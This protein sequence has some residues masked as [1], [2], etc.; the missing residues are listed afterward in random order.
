LWR[1]FC[2]M[3]ALAY[4]VIDTRL[5]LTFIQEAPALSNHIT[6]QFHDCIGNPSLYN[7]KAV[8]FNLS[9]LVPS[10][11]IP[12][13]S[14]IVTRGAGLC[15]SGMLEPIKAVAAFASSV[16]I[17]EAMAA[18]SSSSCSMIASRL[19]LGNA[20]LAASEPAKAIDVHITSSTAL[21]YHPVPPL[22]YCNILP[23]P[24]PSA[25]QAPKNLSA[26]P[27]C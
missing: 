19:H 12:S 15:L 21:L 6:A 23:R 20:L 24:S 8:P 13:Q 26:Q 11:S 3:H 9:C 14:D 25:Y 10:P 4:V 1:W 5:N 18:G 22:H 2:N 7:R 17:Q 27:T 16:Q